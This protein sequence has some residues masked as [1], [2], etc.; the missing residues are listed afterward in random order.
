MDWKKRVNWEKLKTF[1]CVSKLGSFTK[2]GEFLHISQSAV[3]RQVQDLEHQ[4]GCKLFVRDHRHLVLT[5][6]GEIILN[7]VE[8]MM[9]DVEMAYTL[10][11]EES[12]E[13]QGLLKV[14]TTSALATL[15][16]ARFAPDFLK[17]YPKMRLTIIGNDQEL[18]LTIR[19][20]D[21]AIR[22]RIESQPD[23]EQKHLT[24]FHLG[25]YASPQY[26]KEFGSPQH[27]KDL[28][29]HRLLVFGDYTT[30]PYGNINW[31][32]KVG[33]SPEKERIPYMCIN[34]SQGLMWSAEA[35]LGIAGLSQEYAQ[36]NDKLVRVLPSHET[37]TID[38][39]YVYPSH[40]KNS[41]RITVFGDYLA[42]K[43]NKKE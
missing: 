37:P 7:A 24:T 15:W 26:L 12:N 40:F 30:H 16:L 4:V 8:Q 5:K 14:T 2:A 21:V 41:K 11:Q 27:P 38:L 20:A 17:K 31:V 9:S 13:P 18:D 25:L 6:E 43:L 35:G 42:E 19:Q 39:Y 28:D 23:L 34:S 36:E 33:S 3:S 22:P 1:H 10:I 29:D 32:L